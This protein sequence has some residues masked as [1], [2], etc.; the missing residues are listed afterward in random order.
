MN[1]YRG[2]AAILLFKFL[3]NIIACKFRLNTIKQSFNFLEI[4]SLVSEYYKYLEFKFKAAIS[5][6][7]YPLFAPR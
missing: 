3:N 2:M 7:A 6:Y 4:P 1:L 5:S